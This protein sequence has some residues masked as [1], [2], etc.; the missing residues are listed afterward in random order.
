V[1]GDDGKVD[2]DGVYSAARAIPAPFLKPTKLSPPQH[3][4]SLARRSHLI[5]MDAHID[6]AMRGPISRDCSQSNISGPFMGARRALPSR[7]L[8]S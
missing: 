6:E 5:G 8:P 4:D 7:W 2:A 1:A 3:L